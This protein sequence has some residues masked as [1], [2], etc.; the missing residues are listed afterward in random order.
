MKKAKLVLFLI[1]LSLVACNSNANPQVTEAQNTVTLTKSVSETFTPTPENT[2]TPTLVPV[3]IINSQNISQLEFKSALGN[4]HGYLIDIAFSPN[5]SVLV[6]AGLPFIENIATLSFW[7]L[8]DF[9]LIKEFYPNEIRS[10]SSI[11]F[12]PDGDYFAAQIY[13][14]PTGGE[15]QRPLLMIFT[16]ENDMA[17]TKVQTEKNRDFDNIKWSPNGS[18]LVTTGGPP[19]GYLDVYQFPDMNLLYSVK[20]HNAQINS[21][22]FSPDGKVLATAGVDKK[23][24]IIDTTTWEILYTLDGT[25]SNVFDVKFSPDMSFLAIAE[26][27]GVL[28]WDFNT[29]TM[30]KEFNPKFKTFA[31]AYS[32]DGSLLAT[33]GID[34]IIRIWDMKTYEMLVELPRSKTPIK[35]LEFSPNGQWLVSVAEFLR[36][37]NSGAVLEPSQATVWGLPD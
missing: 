8:S 20:F 19:H 14:E 2:S 34:G 37:L 18:V 23:V 21:L 30:I 16:T 5:S 4:H 15:A 35:K 29:K 9:S 12:S 10:L 22:A 3:E 1:F 24:N 17:F 28:L 13:V 36:D 7:N 27:K 25:S 6:T 26:E 31:V 33:G 32:Q 11:V